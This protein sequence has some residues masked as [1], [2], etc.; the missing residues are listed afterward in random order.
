MAAEP[1]AAAVRQI[2][3]EWIRSDPRSFATIARACGVSASQLQR[4][5][6]GDAAMSFEHA[7]KL[8]VALA[9]PPWTL[10]EEARRR[11]CPTAGSISYSGALILFGERTPAQE[12]LDEAMD[13]ARRLV[14]E[15]TEGD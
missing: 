2:L 13:E 15:T 9:R 5:L 3:R 8:C 10:F 11:L 6:S 7:E 12:D 14:G 4:R 1:S